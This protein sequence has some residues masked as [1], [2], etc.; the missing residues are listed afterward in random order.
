MLTLILGGARSGKSDLAER[1][2]TASG[3]SVVVIA[4]MDP[5]D[6]EMRARVD[7]HR[8]RR[9]DSWRTVEEQHDVVAVLDTHAASGDFV[10]VDC[11]TLWVSN[12]L[13]ARLGDA[14]AASVEATAAAIEHA[15]DEAHTLA[16]R[17]A[18]FDGD[19]V[20]VS[21]DVGSGVVPAYP[22][23][24]AFRDALGA[25]NRAVAEQAGCVYWVVAGL[26][27]E[28]KSLGARELESFGGR[29]R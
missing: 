19:V 29:E 8:A 24:R 5:R 22:L 18:A 3:S 9:H 26:A 25:A 2:A 21:N 17:A 15:A 7:Q 16:G 12:L 4:T 1:L 11:I 6:D 27:L 28:L 14:G 10:I 23:G 13:I 20:I